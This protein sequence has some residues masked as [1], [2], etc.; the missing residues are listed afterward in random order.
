VL[1]TLTLDKSAIILAGG[2]SSRF[3]EDKGA[4]ELNHKPLIRHVYDAVE[5]LVEEV[6]VVTDTKQRA[7]IYSK[8]LP[9]DARFTVDVKESSGPL[10]GALSGFEAAQGKY[11][12][13]LPFDMPFVSHEV[14]SLLFDLCI[15]KTAVIPRWTDCKI[16]PLHAVYQTKTALEAAK[17]AADQGALDMQ[18]MVEQLRGVRYVSTLVIEQLDPDMRTFFNVNTPLDLKKAESML[19]RNKKPKH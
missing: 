16:E 17:K 19:Q 18:T 2:S 7:D 14:L 1:E 13:L 4:A 5:D 9:Q 6:V 15:G 3:G 12:L 10:I 8:I 11:S